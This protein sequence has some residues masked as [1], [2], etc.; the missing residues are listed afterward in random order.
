[1]VISTKH[2]PT[3]PEAATP[4][5][6]AYP[7]PA[8]VVG[9]LMNSVFLDVLDQDVLVLE[10]LNRYLERLPHAERNGLRPVK[11]LTLRPSRDLG[12]LARDYESQ[13]PRGFRFLTRG[14]GTRETSSPDAL[15]LVLFQPDYL[16]RLIDQGEADAEAP[17]RG[18]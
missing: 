13:L 15:S 8:Q 4:G 9:A 16:R 5:S 3:D 2:V 17:L 14:L 1:M 10:R 7:P 18:D 6:A 11:L 12:R